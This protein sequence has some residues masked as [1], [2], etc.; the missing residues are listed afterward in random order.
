MVALDFFTVPTV[1]FQLLYC[2]FVIEHA[3]RKILQFNVMRYP[4][5]DWIVQKLRNVFPEAGAMP[6]DDGFGFDDDENELFATS[7]GGLIDA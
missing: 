6:A 2:F 1:T 3:R 5:A 7:G 4:W